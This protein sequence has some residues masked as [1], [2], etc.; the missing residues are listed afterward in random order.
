VCQG[1]KVPGKR[2]ERTKKQR[3]V[4]VPQPPK[5]ENLKWDFKK[6]KMGEEGNRND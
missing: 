6:R 1:L 2:E 4:P 3:T 5:K